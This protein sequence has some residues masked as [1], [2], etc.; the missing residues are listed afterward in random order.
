MKIPCFPILF[1]TLSAVAETL[2]PLPWSAELN[3]PERYLINSSGKLSITRDMTERALKF[4]V[5]FPPGADFWCYPLFTFNRPLENPADAEYLRFDIRA[6]QADDRAG[7]G[8]VLVFVDE[9]RLPYPA[10]TGE[11]RTVT[12]KLAD[13]GKS[14][15]EIQGI[16]IGMNPKSSRLTYFLR[17]IELLSTR[18]YQGP[19]DTA[20]MV[21]TTAPG[22]VFTATESPEFSLSWPLETKW[23]VRDWRGGEIASGSWP[24]GGRNSLRLDP[25]PPGYYTL[26]LAS[27]TLHCT[28]RRSFTVVVDPA[29]RLRNANSFFALDTAQSW[30]AGPNPAN[31]RLPGAGYEAVSELVRR[32]GVENVRERLSWSDVEPEPGRFEGLQYMT[33]A[34][35]LAERGIG[36]LGMYHNAPQWARDRSSK[37]PD[38]LLATYRFA[39]LAATEFAGKMRAWEFWN[40][41]DIG[42][43]EEPAWDYAAALKAAG[44]GFKAADPTLPVLIGGI[45]ITPLAAYNDVVMQNDAGAYFDVFNVH[46]YRPLR[47]FPAIVDNIRGF[48][49]KHAI[50]DK[51]LWFTENGSN[52]EGSGRIQGC[53]P[54][55]KA[56]SPDQELLVAEYLPKSMIYLQSLGVDRDYFFVLSPY[57][58]QNGSKDWGLLRRDYSAKPGYAALATLTGCLNSAE[59]LGELKINDAVRAFLYR[60]P[61]GKQTIA[62]WSLS[63]LDRDPLRPDLTPA[64]DFTAHFTIP[65]AD[66][67]YLLTDLVGGVS[68]VTASGGKLTLKSDRFPAYVTGLSGLVPDLKRPQRPPAQRPEELDRTIISRVVLSDDFSVSAGKDRAEVKHIPAR[69]TLQLYNLSDREKSGSVSIAGGEVT[70]L[71]DAIHLPAFG[72]VEIPLK[73]TP[74]IPKG[75]YQ[76]D[77]IVSGR[78][79]D[80]PISK[81]TMPIASFDKMVSEG[82]VVELINAADPQNWRKNASGRME[83]SFDRQEHALSFRTKFPPNVADRWVYP[84]YIL[85][86]PQES[87]R[88]ASG[89][90]FEYRATPATAVKQMLLMAVFSREKEHGYAINLQVRKPSESWQNCVLPIDKI[91]DPGKIE[92]LRIGVNSNAEEIT[93]QIRNFKVLYRP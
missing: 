93:Y 13:A 73:L 90:S 83:I 6:V 52:A 33:N 17:N 70:G 22:T 88:G 56:H 32:V 91:G 57:N 47:D 45:A 12:L 9:K 7:F 54:G 84:E 8:P 21:R 64:Q 59:Y 44:L 65:A 19:V 76:V 37:L 80:R 34:R 5:T 68:E 81:L 48:M 4:D 26:E 62:Y 30:L 51:P 24:E 43:T 58:E 14:P 75:N 1:L 78:F 53:T 18:P 79:L 10:P 35:L 16:K 23:K 66:G 71:P 69:L 67:G 60:Q 15:D 3:R 27:E 82:R 77:F 49:K 55:F 42:F 41:Q 72:K 85:Q 38:D 87:L 74:G 92:M 31:P 39:K 25:L 20:A 2:Y 29:T 40:E 28:G 46:T 61:D 63:E 36:V 86:L 89:V 11:W 50:A